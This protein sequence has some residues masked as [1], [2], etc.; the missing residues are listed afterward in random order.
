MTIGE[1]GRNERKED[2]VGNREGCEEC[3]EGGEE[4]EGVTKDTGSAKGRR[5]RRAARADDSAPVQNGKRLGV[6]GVHENGA[7]RSYR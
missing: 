1:A 5:R 4:D 7:W 2:D 3:E 6:S